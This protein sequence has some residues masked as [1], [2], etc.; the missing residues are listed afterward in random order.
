[1]EKSKLLHQ[2]SSMTNW[3]IQSME[4]NKQGFIRKRNLDFLLEETPGIIKVITGQ[5]KSGKTFLIRQF[6]Y[7]L[8]QNRNVKSKNIFYLNFDYDETGSVK[9]SIK[10]TA[11]IETFIS[12]LAPGDKTYIILDELQS[13]KSWPKMLR[14]VLRNRKLNFEIIITGSSFEDFRPSLEKYFPDKFIHKIVYPFSYKEYLQY[15]S[16][17]SS[18]DELVRFLGVGGMIEIY[19]LEKDSVKQI[20]I[21]SM[22]KNI[23]EKDISAKFKLKATNFF[24]EM[25]IYIIK[26]I[27]NLISLKT[28]TSDLK[29]GMRR[30]SSRT[31]FN[32]L[33]M[34]E[35]YNILYSVGVY[36]EKDKKNKSSKKY[37]LTE[38][39]IF[40]YPEAN[41]ESDFIKRLENYIGNTL[42]LEGFEIYSANRDNISCYVAE[43]GAHKLMIY[44]DKNQSGFM[45]SEYNYMETIKITMDEDKIQRND[46]ATIVPAWLF[47]EFIDGILK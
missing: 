29:S 26:N 15:N 8:V 11:L 34:L 42:F 7:E 40:N 41:I 32:Y 4:Q 44:M 27:G 33:R 9:T 19:N 13:V 30:L 22:V 38:L 6:I 2:I 31:V 43:K 35:Y 1:M 18:R 14:Y 39:S 24:E 21:N 5:R 37:F 23:I 16:K 10:L 46:N 28:I 12:S 36:K 3:S 17:K 25:L 45:N 20:T 47:P